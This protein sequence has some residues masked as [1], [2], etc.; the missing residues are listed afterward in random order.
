MEKAIT[1][2]DDPNIKVLFS[3]TQK[4]ETHLWHVFLD[5]V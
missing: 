5:S 3:S 4:A 2:A 1:H